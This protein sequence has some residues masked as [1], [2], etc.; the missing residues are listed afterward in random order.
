M[1]GPGV[2]QSQHNNRSKKK[3][4]RLCGER[5]RK[6]KST[7]GTGG[8]LHNTEE[9]LGACPQLEKREK[10]KTKGQRYVT[11][12][13]YKK[14]RQR[15]GRVTI[16]NFHKKKTGSNQKGNS[17][18]GEKQAGKNKLSIT[19]GIPYGGSGQRSQLRRRMHI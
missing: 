15:S 12:Y 7:I 9:D 18:R 13:L 5:K 11:G 16:E 19:V 17:V 14:K 2:P 8:G 6:T 4:N 3:R 10:R 1:G